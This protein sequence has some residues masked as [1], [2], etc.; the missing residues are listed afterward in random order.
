MSK[1]LKIALASM[2][3]FAFVLTANASAPAT[4]FAGNMMMG[5][6]GQGVKELQMF[7]NACPDTALAVNAGTAGSVGYETM[8]F[9]PAT[10][11]AVMKYQA[12][13][14]VITT[15]NFYPLTRAQASAVG[16]VCG[17]VVGGTF[18]PAGCTSASGYSPV[19]GGACYAVGAATFAPA[20]CTAASG[21]SPVTGGAC[22]AVGANP[23]ANGPLAGTAGTISDVNEL[24]Q[25]DNQEVSD[26]ENDV[27]VVGFEVEASNDGDIQLTSAKLR[28]TITNGSG[29]TRLEDYVDSVSV[30]QGNTKVGSADAT[31]FTKDATGVYTKI[32]TL[33]SAIVR[34]DSTEKFYV[35]VDAQSNLD[36]GDIDSETMTVDVDN[37]RYVDG[38]GV[39]TTDVDT[40]DIN[41]MNFTAKFVSFAT[42]ADTELKVSA[43][44]NN[45]L[46]TV[47]KVST[48]ADTNN[49][50]LLK[51]K[52]KLEGT[53]DVWV[54][55]MQFTLTT[56]GDSIDALAKSVSLKLGNNTYTESLG[57]NCTPTCAANT[58]AV[59]TFDNLD[60][61]VD[62]DA[63]VAFTITAD[64]NDLENTGVTATDFDEGD[65]LL[66]SLLTTDRDNI[67]AENAQ[68]DQLVDGTEMTGSAVGNAM[69]FR[70]TGISL[71]LVGSPTASVAKGLAGSPDLGTYTMT[72]DATAFGGNMYIDG[73]KPNLTGTAAADLDIIP[74]AGG[75]GTQDATIVSIA[76]S[77]SIATRTGTINADARFL[78]PEGETKRFVITSVVTPTVAGGQYSVALA[79]LRY[80]V[81]DV[82]GTL[83]YT[84]NLV[85]FVTPS[86]NLVLAN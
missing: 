3:A 57:A 70:S 15:G 36:S 48:T 86:V 79:A 34:S 7:L 25:Y 14:G 16:N 68:G 22:Y 24:S 50:T 30:W 12:K 32:V 45:P 29:S 21:F 28:F 46:A 81:T 11:A 26:G 85:D 61:N 31:D 58:T 82:T 20:G 72:F 84:T 35:A 10:K 47:V 71:V 75:T 41:D 40:G 80:D 76:G 67:V 54:D 74:G 37:I 27:K 62:A 60:Y 17:G 13:V 6:T 63:T 9:G 2:F 5:S 64:L 59:V 44:T 33:N 52:M 51:G 83:N 18:A 56:T 65:T 19:T 55:E 66:A 1:T 42:A 77:G 39:T 69:T 38:S 49:V 8:T 4:N 43:D 78:V 53:S 23:P 73:T